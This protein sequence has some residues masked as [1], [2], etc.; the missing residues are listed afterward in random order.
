MAKIG[1]TIV[2]WPKPILTV[3]VA[4]AIIGLAA[5]PGYRTSYD[6]RRY[7][8]KDIP[9]NAGFLAADRHFSQARMQPEILLIESDH[10]LRNPADFLVVDKVTKAVF[11]YL[12]LRAFRPSPDPKALP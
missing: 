10:D 12:A 7:I 6:D 9:A 1:A 11:Q 5:L 4:I 8:P 2:R 3:S